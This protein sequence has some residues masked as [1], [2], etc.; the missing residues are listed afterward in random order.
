MNLSDHLFR[1]NVNRFKSEIRQVILGTEVILSSI[2]VQL[3]LYTFDSES[4][5]L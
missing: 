2:H 1:Q 4:Y 5:A 3:G